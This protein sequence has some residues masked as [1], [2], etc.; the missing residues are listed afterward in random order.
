[1]CRKQIE[2]NIKLKEAQRE[3]ERVEALIKVRGTDLLGKLFEEKK[4]I[5]YDKMKK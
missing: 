2:D 1:V 4:H 5:S 3:K